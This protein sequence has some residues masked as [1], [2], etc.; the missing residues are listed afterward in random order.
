MGPGKGRVEM[1]AW[2]RHPVIYEV[3]TWV[4]LGELSRKHQRP[5]DLGTVPVQEWDALAAPGFDAIWF[6]GVWE[7][8]PAGVEI[9]MRNPG[10]LEDFRRALPDFA[11]EDNVGSPYCVRRYVVDEHLGGPKGLAVARRRLAERGLRLILDFVPNHVAP[12][13]PWAS[14]HPEYFVRG[15]AEDAGSDPASFV[16]LGG[17]VFARGRDPFFPAWP[18]VL[19]LDAFQPDLRQA[20]I[21]TLSEIA[22]QCDGV[23]CDMAMLALNDVFERTWGSRAGPRP[24][25]DYWATVITTTRRKH[26]QFRFI[27]EAYWDLEW[28][29]QQQG[30]DHCYDKKLYDRLE[31]GDAESIRL[32]LLAD[33]AY[34]QGM[35][36]FIENHDEPRAAAAFPSG[37]GRAAAVAMLTLT[38]LKLLHEGQ[39][40]GRKVR[41]PVF[42]GRRPAEPIDRDLIA[43]YARVLAVVTND[44]FRNGE[45]RLC[46]RSG[47]PDNQSHLNVLAWCWDLG[48]ERRLVVVNFRQE[49]SQALV[50]V[51]WDELRGRTW[52]LHD[53]LSGDSHDRN[54]DEMRDAG[55]YVDLK[56][57]QCH[58]FQVGEP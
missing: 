19:Q 31:H 22:R 57:W 17:T 20:V 33:R 4:W 3:N 51:P 41:L 29:L 18:D 26:P 49:A 1:K 40:E 52:R 48:D 27:A 43:F 56:P 36:R 30:F 47:W 50:H 21:E 16:E 10:L 25:D 34:Q 24:A 8:S 35:V 37:K 15:T 9:S 38:G 14:Q 12:D 44:V 45:W 53:S 13:H 55:L 54:G 32:H 11:P 5:V 42:L 23:R 39:F 58:L 46:E 6:M 28:E 2:T 7:R